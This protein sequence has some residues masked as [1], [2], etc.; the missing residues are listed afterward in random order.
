MTKGDKKTDAFSITLPTQA[1]DMIE[2]L[3]AEGLYGTTR[4]EIARQLILDQ[5]KVMKAERR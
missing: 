2:G 3:I 5:L 1:I 4:A